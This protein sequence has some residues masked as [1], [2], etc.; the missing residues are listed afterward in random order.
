METE[1]CLK[2]GHENPEGFK[3]CNECGKSR[4]PQVTEKR[5]ANLVDI[6][7]DADL[8]RVATHLF[9]DEQYIPSASELRK[10]LER[11][12]TDNQRQCF[13]RVMRLHL[14]G[15]QGREAYTTVAAERNGSSTAVSSAFDRASSMIGRYL[16]KSRMNALYE[17][18]NE[19]DLV[20]ATK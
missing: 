5:F 10:A 9:G 4:N 17:R 19:A 2:C 7:E 16:N 8:S 13:I 1:T 6:H 14:P 11:L 18:D 3:F 20:I 12:P 15:K